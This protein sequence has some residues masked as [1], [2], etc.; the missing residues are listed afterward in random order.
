MNVTCAVRFE[1]R[2]C[3]VRKLPKQNLQGSAR[4]EKSRGTTVR[5]LQDEII[6][7]E[8]GNSNRRLEFLDPGIC[9]CPYSRFQK[10]ILGDSTSPRLELQKKVERD[11]GRQPEPADLVLP[12]G[13]GAFAHQARQIH[14]APSGSR[15]CPTTCR[16]RFLPRS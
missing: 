6:T 5:I 12:I 11:V 9:T 2:A 15:R 16:R 4:I 3:F 8:P 14:F 7:W 13:T 1:K 10:E